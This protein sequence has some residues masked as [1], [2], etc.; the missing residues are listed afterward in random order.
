MNVFKVL[1]FDPHTMQRSQPVGG[2]S[3]PQDA[4]VFLSKLS[5]TISQLLQAFSRYLGPIKSALTVVPPS[6]L[7]CW[8]FCAINV[9]IFLSLSSAKRYSGKIAKD[10]QR[11]A[12]VGGASTQPC[13]RRALQS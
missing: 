7:L 8:D 11:V 4:L 9:C 3:P 13:A 2:P 10:N 12:P 1:G 5:S 6:A